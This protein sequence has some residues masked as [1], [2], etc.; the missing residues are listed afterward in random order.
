LESCNSGLVCISI[1]ISLIRNVK[2]WCLS[3]ISWLEAVLP[4]SETGYINSW[5]AASTYLLE[6]GHEVLQNWYIIVKLV[7]LRCIRIEEPIEDTYIFWF[8][9]LC[10]EISLIITVRVCEIVDCWFKFSLPRKV[11]SLINLCSPVPTCLNS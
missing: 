11:S 7:M 5:L 8:N 9:I 3:I 6:C 4:F 1:T 10:I 2:F